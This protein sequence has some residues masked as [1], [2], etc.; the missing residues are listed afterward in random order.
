MQSGFR[1]GD[2][3][4]EGVNRGVMHYEVMPWPLRLEADEDVAAYLGRAVSVLPVS[5]MA[6]YFGR[7]ESTLV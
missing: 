1:L 4:L 7:D 2:L 3:R 6:R 5:R